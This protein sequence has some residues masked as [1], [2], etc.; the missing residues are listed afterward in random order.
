MNLQDFA[1]E[2]IR[3]A[4]LRTSPYIHFVCDGIFPED[5]YQRMLKMHPPIKWMMPYG[6][7]HRAGRYVVNLT[8][9]EWGGPKSRN[10]TLHHMRD[11]SM[12]DFWNRF[13][14]QV[15][16]PELGNAINERL[17]A[18]TGVR[19]NIAAKLSTDIYG[20]GLGPHLD[21]AYKTVSSL[22]YLAPDE[23]EKQS[24]GTELCWPKDPEEFVK[25]EEDR[26]VH[27]P[28]DKFDFIGMLE[29][30]P[31]RMVGWLVYNKSWHSY[32]QRCKDK[33]RHL[34]RAYTF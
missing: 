27:W 12:R 24:M 22:I 25:F 15:F 11:R 32:E 28:R 14:L 5:Y 4:E 29:Y 33:E 20:A 9:D 16:T 18:P 34:I 26:N 6:P 2:R 31:N 10:P 17:G 21:G 19:N 7:E 13:Q 1:I 23:S 3:G 30:V 8:G